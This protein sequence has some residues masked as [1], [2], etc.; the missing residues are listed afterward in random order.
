[1]PFKAFGLKGHMM[2]DKNAKEFWSRKHAENWTHPRLPEAEI[3][4]L[5]HAHLTGF[6]LAID[7]GHLAAIGAEVLPALR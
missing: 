6:N 5:S 2:R 7:P 4:A 3:D 1:M